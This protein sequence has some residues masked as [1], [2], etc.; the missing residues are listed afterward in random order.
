MARSIR[1]FLLLTMLLISFNATATRMLN[2]LERYDLSS[3]SYWHYNP[4]SCE[5]SASLVDSDGYVHRV[6]V[7]SSIGKNDG[8]VTKINKHR[9]EIIELYPDGDGG[10]VE[11]PT[12][13][14]FSN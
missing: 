6:I 9:I 3:L 5:V 11:K 12:S 8:R 14:E 10:W 4:S 13:I 7:G 2:E 1:F